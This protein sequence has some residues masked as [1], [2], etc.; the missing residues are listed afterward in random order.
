M[1]LKKFLAKYAGEVGTIATVLQAILPA[2]PIGSQDKAKIDAAIEQFE[3][4]AE[5]IAKS[6]AEAPAELGRV[7]VR[8]S[9]VVSAVNDYLDAHPEVIAAAIA[10]KANEGNGNA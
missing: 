10:A 5:N 8:K 1:N 4:A 7:V 3:T 2:I 9:D 6:A